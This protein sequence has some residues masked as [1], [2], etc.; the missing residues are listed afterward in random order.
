MKSILN[1][2]TDKDFASADE[3]NIPP[4]VWYGQTTTQ[5]NG[6]FHYFEASQQYHNMESNFSGRVGEAVPGVAY[7][8]DS[9]KVIYNNM[10]P[11]I[12]AAGQET[13]TT[14]EEFGITRQIYNQL[15]MMLMNREPMDAFNIT[16]GGLKIIGAGIGQPDGD[17]NPTEYLMFDTPRLTMYITVD[18]NVNIYSNIV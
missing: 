18:G 13:G 15:H 11:K 9:G 8:K 16:I 2:Q 7:L 17:L 3:N 14:W 10:Y 1:Y 4:Y 6:T 12:E 5:S